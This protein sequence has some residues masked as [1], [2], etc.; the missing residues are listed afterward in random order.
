MDKSLVLRDFFGGV[1]LVCCFG[2][3]GI[4]NLGPCAC[5]IKVLN[6]HYSSEN[7]KMANIHM[8]KCSIA[9]ATIEV[10]IKTIRCHFTPRTDNCH[11]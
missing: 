9:L 6:R 4:L 11:Q 1:V 5:W 8:K 7:I 2:S 3:M 10:V